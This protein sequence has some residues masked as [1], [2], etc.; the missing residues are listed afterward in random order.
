MELATIVM[1]D[2]LRYAKVLVEMRELQRAELE[3]AE[4]LE[5]T[6]EHLDALSLF[7]KIKHMRGQLS[8]AVACSAQL[9]SRSSTTGEQARMHLESMLHM[10]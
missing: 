7:T 2:R 5:E 9:Q 4:I 6:P 3:V 10:A 1:Q 8:L